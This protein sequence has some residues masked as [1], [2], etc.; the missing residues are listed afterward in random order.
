[1]KMYC[2]DEK[3]EVEV[4]R[5]RVKEIESEV[6]QLISLK[7][8]AGVDGNNDV[9]VYRVSVASITFRRKKI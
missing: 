7:A 3:N 9:H 4:A 8:V 2:I 6:R 5:V 1:M